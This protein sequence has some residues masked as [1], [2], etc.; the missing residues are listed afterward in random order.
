MVY[1]DHAATSPLHP[2]VLDAMLPYLQSNYGN[3][4]SI[5]QR[6]RQA[7]QGLDQAR[8]QIAA[9][10]A[11]K[12]QTLVF[13]SG[14]TEA[15][16]MAILG[17]ALEHA[18]KGK[19]IITSQIEHHA[20]LHACKELEER[21]YD[22]TYVKVDEYGQVN[23]K[24]I[25]AALRDDTILVTI[26]YGN[27]EVG[28]VQPIVE[29]GE[30]LKDHQAVFHTDAVQACGAL[31]VKIAELP[32]DMLSISAHKLNGPKGIG[33]LYIKNGLTLRP[34]LYGG[35]QER[36]RRAGTEN[37][38]SIVGF[39][40]ALQISNATIKERHDKYQ[41]FTHTLL[42]TWTEKQVD[43]YVN[44]HQT[45]RLPHIV[46]ISFP[47]VNLESLL[48]NLDMAGISASSGSACTA[49]SV[50]ASHVLVAMFGENSERSQAAV[51]FSFGF[52]NTE[53]QIKYV[54]EETAKIVNRLK[55]QQEFIS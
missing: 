5:H 55:Q 17:Y 14:G 10:L 32:V 26:M 41:R 44:G 20:V 18:D 2:E 16:N 8:A 7:R 39:A 9:A 31:E 36:K 42:D 48:M 29:I 28:T 37:V 23:P 24:D 19:H 35:E 46:N 51:R 40:K 34:L 38:A 33:L 45:E 6:G 21:G 15:D 53:E 12:E 25:E 50:E 22:V 54:A 1:V 30:L 49:G 3:P 27:N 47:G 11:V 4:S 43:F 52:D 13:T